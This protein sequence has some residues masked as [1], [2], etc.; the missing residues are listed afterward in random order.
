MDARPA[1]NRPIRSMTGYAQVRRATAAGELTLSLRTVNH[2]GLDLHFYMSGDLAPFENSM[3]SAIKQEV[4]RGHVELRAGLSRQ[5]TGEAAGYD[6]K[7]LGRY[8][9]AFRE[10]SNEFGLSGQPDLNVFLT[11]PGVFTNQM[12]AEPLDDVFEA[13][14]LSALAEC[15]TELNASRE[16]EGAA[17]AKD[18]E[19]ILKDVEVAV[20]SI[21]AARG[22][23]LSYFQTRLRE[24][25]QEL[26]EGAG[27]PEARVVE[28]A[29]LLADKSDIQE[30]LT[31]L[32]VH[33]QELKRMLEAGGELGKRLDFLLQEI[34]RE[35]NTTLAKSSGAGE[36]GLEITNLALSIKA[37]IER[38]REQALNFE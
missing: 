4:S 13:E 24:R 5:S 7:A 22:R 36:P 9:A 25:L 1:L 2:R 29:A 32:T 27:L 35:T 10:A 33:A 12:P 18:L 19:C 6:S 15:L 21:G 26:L 16:R 17:L 30:E 31:R 8:L 34:S 38:M 37:N 23:A 3:R 11:L 20:T 28:E 14:V